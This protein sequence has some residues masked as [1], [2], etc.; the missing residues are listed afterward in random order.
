MPDDDKRDR[1]EG[2]LDQQ[3]APLPP[4]P[5]TFD[6]ITRRARRRKIRNVVATAASGAV[7][8]AAVVFG[9]TNTTAFRLTTPSESAQV[10]AGQGQAQ[11]AIRS[12]AGNSPGQRADGSASAAPRASASAATVPP[13]GGGQSLPAAVP[14]N[15]APT[16][17]TFVSATK[18]WVIGQAGTPGTC[19]NGDICTSVATTSDGGTTWQGEHA[20]V[21]GAPSGAAGVSGIRFLNG[22]DGWAFGPELWATHDG[23]S[24]WTAV[25]TGGARVTDLETAGDRAYALFATCSGSSASFA[26][27]CT[28]YTL[29]TA[30]AGSGGWTPVG[31]ATSRLSAGGAATS[32]MLELTGSTGYLIAPD[33]SVYSGPIG[34]TWSKAGTAPCQ[35]GAA[36]PGGLPS[37][38]QLA[39]QDASHLALACASAAGGSTVYTST[40]G[41][42]TWS[43]RAA[44]GAA[45]TGTLT[46]LAA[47]PGG[48][49]VLA[50]ANGIYVLP[51]GGT[52]WQSASTASG[53]GLPSGGFSYVGMTSDTQGVAVPANTSLHEV[54]LTSDGGLTWSPSPI[55]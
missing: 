4:P 2:W 5:G 52:N 17:V 53:S 3:I 40:D 7:V 24:T 20:P 46:S 51:A 35:P 48:T 32:A 36:Q 41:G 37:G 25:S 23:G 15:F 10:A 26:A 28:G 39:V 49:L 6:L 14:A 54:W 47:A 18:A 21:T 30:T 8:A 42:A 38:V 55:G 1:L 45:S 27:D 31:T 33:G 50:T 12:G 29:E 9:V 22:V 44:P 34:G 13:A 19:Y 43:A 16:S 11:T